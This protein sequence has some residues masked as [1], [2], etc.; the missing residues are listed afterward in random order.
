MTSNRSPTRSTMR[1]NKTWTWMTTAFQNNY[2]DN[3]Q[4][5]GR[6]DEK[7]E[8]YHNASKATKKNYRG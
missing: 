1:T 3:K 7:S 4:K 8:K 5:R 6:F 2:A